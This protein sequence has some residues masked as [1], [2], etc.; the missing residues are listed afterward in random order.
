MSNYLTIDVEDYYQVSA[1]E[2]IIA[3]DD[4]NSYPSRVVDNTRKILSLLDANGVKAT[5]FILGWTAG[6][7]PELVR[8]ISGKGHEIGCHSFFHRLV[9]DLSPDEFREDTKQAKDILEQ[10]TGRKVIGYRAPS[11]SVTSRS[12]W[13]LDIL[14][15]LGFE[16]DSSIFPIYHDR[17]G[18][19]DAPRF[20]YRLP[21]R[22]LTEYP[23]S[24]SLFFGKK[25][26]VA[27]GGYFRLF[28]YWFSRMALQRI[29]Q[30]EGKPFI[31][32][33][34]PWEI[35]PEQPR[36]K[37]AS[38]LAFFRHHLNLT[39]TWN[40]LEK[41]LQDFAFIPLGTDRISSS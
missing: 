25:V 22:N 17:Y 41:L 9:Y 28:P 30:K 13:A 20:S 8:E 1:F 16:Y 10:L 32:Y 35:D 29:N 39:R 38:P 24:T 34:H 26:P 3:K 7:H 23:L 4:W 15:E 6:K 40:R 36:I 11:Y 27:G 21:D 14:A 31:F 2:N 18:I 33:F 5:F 12:L 19:P 37:G